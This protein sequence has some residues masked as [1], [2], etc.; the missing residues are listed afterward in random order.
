MSN[1]LNR[2]GGYGQGGNP[3]GLPPQANMQLLGAMTQMSQM[4]KMGKGINEILTMFKRRGLTP[5]LV[6]RALCLA[7]PEMAQLAQEMK[8]KSVEQ[9]ISEKAQSM[10]MSPEQAM[11]AYKQVT[12]N[13]KF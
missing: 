8:G 7:S 10:G 6:E 9:F 12:G 1:P 5:D 3:T 11:Q 13:L 4:L 2:G